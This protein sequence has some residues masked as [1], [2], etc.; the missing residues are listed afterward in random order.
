MY[1]YILPR[2]AI[3]IAEPYQPKPIPLCPRRKRIA[4]Q[5]QFMSPAKLVGEDR[6]FLSSHLPKPKAYRKAALESYKNVWVKAMEGKPPH[7][8][9]NEGRKAANL[10][11]L[12]NFNYTSG[13]T[14][15][16]P[17]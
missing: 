17:C 8:A 2:F 3:Y 9:Q 5:D 6:I 13:Y 1:F 16:S 11:L 10:W 4:D 14:K 15:Y 12:T 7:Q